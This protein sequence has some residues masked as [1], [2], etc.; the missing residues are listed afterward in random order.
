MLKQRVITA[1]ALSAAF[2]LAL[3]AASP[4]YFIA[5]SS[6]VILLA[7]WECAALAGLR[8]LPVRL[9]YLALQALLMG[10]LFFGAGI[11]VGDVATLLS[12]PPASLALLYFSPLFWLLFFF[13]LLIFSPQRLLSCAAFFRAVIGAL[14]LLSAWLALLYLRLQ[15]QGQWWI[16]YL[17]AL[18]AATDSGAYFAGRRWGEKKLA[19]QL[20]PGKTWAGFFGGLLAAILLALLFALWLF[21]L[22]AVAV[23]PLWLFVGV[24]IDLAILSV[25][26]DLFE[27]LLKRSAGVKDSGS[28]LPGHGGV[29]DRID[30][31]LASLPAFALI[32]IIFSW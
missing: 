14:L 25:L 26:G 22:N 31:L 32:T 3:T 5:F 4:L 18:V 20:S 12:L 7:T 27:S 30:G 13:S 16:V 17:V 19:P 28:I 21:P 9:A 15:P 6:L 2:L 8:A 10:W 23:P 11:G 24:A 29:M 1:L